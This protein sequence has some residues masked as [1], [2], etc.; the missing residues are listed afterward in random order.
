MW[1]PSESGSGNGLQI[2]CDYQVR[3][4]IVVYVLERADSSALCLICFE[5]RSLRTR[6]DYEAAL[7][8]SEEH[9][10]DLVCLAGYMT[11][12]PCWRLMKVEHPSLLRQNFQEL[13][14][15]EDAFGSW[16]Y[17][18]VAWPFTWVDSVRMV[19]GYNKYAYHDDD[20]TIALKLAVFMRLSKLYPGVG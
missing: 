5:S 13:M 20:T 2:L 10:I 14:E 8:S 3:R 7:S 18:A 11:A 12:Q 9:Q 15:S 4:L 16:C 6:R 17:W 19:V 1:V